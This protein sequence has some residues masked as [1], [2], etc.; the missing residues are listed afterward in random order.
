MSDSA[1]PVRVLLVDNYDSF[2][3]NLA[4]LFGTFGAQ[5]DVVRNDAPGLDRA[6]VAAHDAVC[7][8]PGPGR[9][10]DA[11]KTL[12]TIGWALETQRP[13]LGVCLGLQAIGQYFGGVVEHAPHLMHGR[14]RR[15]RTTAAA[16][17]ATS[18]RLFKRRAI[19]R[20]A[21]RT[22]LFPPC[23]GPTPRATT[24]SCKAPHIV[25]YPFTA[26][27]SIRNPS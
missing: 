12:D 24:A 3:H 17:S 4:H 2:T 16:S 20:C 9:P 10:S 14:R 8:G 19:T 23:C 7:I 21:S 13:L 1:R 18:R 25:R 6:A 22:R 15:S 11:G 5:V 27:S 26:C